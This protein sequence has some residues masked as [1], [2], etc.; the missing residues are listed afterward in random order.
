MKNILTILRD[1]KGVISGDDSM[2]LGA[3]AAF[4]EAGKD[5][6]IVVG[7]AGGS[8]V[9]KSIRSAVDEG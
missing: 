6:A 5:N 8:D 2:A 4:K 7:F 1:I 3:Y 9:L